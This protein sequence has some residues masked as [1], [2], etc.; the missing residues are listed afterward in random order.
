M[1]FRN[2]ANEI[3]QTVCP[4]YM[5]HSQSVYAQ[6]AHHVEFDAFW[7]S[8]KWDDEIVESKTLRMRF[9]HSSHSISWHP[10]N[11]YPSLAYDASA[12]IYASPFVLTLFLFLFRIQ[13][14][15]CTRERKSIKWKISK[16]IVCMGK[17]ST[18]QNLYN[19]SGRRDY[20]V[21]AK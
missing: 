13:I 14:A 9:P 2:G 7:L 16:K 18:H 1:E 12:M 3:W 6:L 4:V 21:L 5:R 10:T 11:V 20:L 8:A 15:L 19:S 17:E